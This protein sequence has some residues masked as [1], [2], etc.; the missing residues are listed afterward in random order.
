MLV[1]PTSVFSLVFFHVLLMYFPAVGH[2]NFDP[3]SNFSRL[4]AVS[5]WT[6][7]HQQH[8]M[9]GQP[10]NFGFLTLFWDKAFG[11]Q[12]QRSQQ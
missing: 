12:Y 6:R 8:H 10:G 11:T 3:Y 1:W 7:F 2:S 5:D 9:L 4:R